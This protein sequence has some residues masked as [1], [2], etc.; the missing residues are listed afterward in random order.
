[1]VLL[2][3]FNLDIVIFIFCRLRILLFYSKECGLLLFLVAINFIEFKLWIKFCPLSNKSNIHLDL[4]FILTPGACP[5]RV[6]FRSQSEI[7][8][9]LCTEFGAIPLWLSPSLY[10]LYFPHLLLPW[11]L[12]FDPFSHKLCGFLLEFYILHAIRHFLLLS[13]NSSPL[14]TAF[15][16]SL[17]PLGFLYFAQ[18]LLLLF[19]G[20]LV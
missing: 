4:Q 14:L 9:D 17:L 11:T 18:S 15:F 6:W 1:M 19:A 12:S 10:S 8:A 20:V 7:W 13:V 16:Y 3:G 2:C 5:V